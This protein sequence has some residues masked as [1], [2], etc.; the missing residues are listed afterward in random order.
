M[1]ETAG[2][3]LDDAVKRMK[4]V[5]QDPDFMMQAARKDFVLEDSNTWEV[6]DDYAENWLK[7]GDHI[8]N[9]MYGWANWQ[10]KI[11]RQ[12]WLRTGVTGMSSIDAYTDTFMAT[13]QSRL[14]AYDEVF[15]KHGKSIDPEVFTQKLKNAEELNYSKMFDKQGLLK[16]GAAKTASG[17]IALNLDDGFSKAINPWLNKMPVLK[18]LMMFPRTSMNQLKLA[19]SY[20]PIS[21]IPGIGKYGDVLMAARTND[22][23]LIKKTLLDHGVKNFD[24]TPEAMAIFRNLKDEYEGRL[25][26]GA[27]TTALAYMY[28]MS[29][30]VRGNGPVNHNELV[31][32]KKKGWKPNTIKIGN[33]WVSYKGIPMVEQFLN[34]MGD[35]AFYQTA[36]GSNMTEELHSKVMWTIAATYLNQSPLQGIEPIAAM[37]RGDEGAFK[38]LAAQNIRAASF[39]S[40]LHGVIAKGITNAQKEIY[41]DF[42]GY[43]RNNTVF[44]DMS[45]S[46][47]DHWTGEEIDEIDNPILRALNAINPVKV[48][49]GNEPW[50]LWLLNSGFDDLAEIKTS[51]KGITYTPEERE[52]IGKFMGQQQLWKRIDS[53]EFMHNKVFNRDLDKLR[54]YINSGADEAEVANHRNKLDVYEKL[55]KMINQAKEKAE[56]QIANDDRYKHIDIL[57]LGNQKVKNL[58]DANDIDGAASQARK[59]YAKKKEFLK[60]GVKN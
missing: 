36:L 51:S 1:F 13:F 14:S 40:G 43:V 45:Y 3:A 57:G 26:M 27:G 16:D 48:H 58:M 54:Q 25:M 15:T 35:M 41:N 34:L 55:K 32:L 19:L 29:G 8:N 4:K 37:I 39:Q 52:L 31:K 21:A 24:E 17:E 60:Y 11:A 30:G 59:N 28:A 20:T 18:S 9:F 10:R 38:R 44:K 7:D 23:E 56:R 2:R 47:I 50:R 12:P 53:K 49:G 22:M 42:L 33:S 6:L 5:H 46:K